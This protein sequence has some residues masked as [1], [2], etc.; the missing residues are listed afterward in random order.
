MASPVLPV[1]PDVVQ[2]VRA[3]VDRLGE[4]QAGLALGLSPLT[5]FR[6][7]AGSPVTRGTLL[8]L[9]RALAAA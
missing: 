5:V 2:K 9:E 1:A 7:L 3:L 4:R 6:I 8:Q